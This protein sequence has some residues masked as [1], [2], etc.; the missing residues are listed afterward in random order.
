VLVHAYPDALSVAPLASAEGW[1]ILITKTA[2]LP[3]ATASAIE[4]SGAGA[5]LVVGSSSAISY[6][7]QDDLP[8]PTRVGGRDRYETSAQLAAYAAT[9]GCSFRHVALATGATF[10][11]G[12]V[13]A[14]Y[15]ALDRGLLLLTRTD[16]MPPPLTSAISG[17]R[18][19]IERL[20]A[21]GSKRS[22][23]EG[24]LYEAAA[25]LDWS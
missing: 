3:A 4:S 19:V 18:A 22:V 15:L 11:D 8:S 6:D 14:P 21:I 12:L 2:T 20:D 5:S 1:P 13:A 17:N 7:V 23:N 24:V 16:I 25:A 10:P 9:H